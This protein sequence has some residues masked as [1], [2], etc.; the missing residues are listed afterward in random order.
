TRVYAKACLEVADR[1]EVHAMAHITGGGLAANLARV[2]PDS[3]EAT[4][5][6]AT[7]TLPA[8]FEVTR[9]VGGLTRADV[10]QA[11]NCGVGMVLVLPPSEV[12]TAVDVLGGYG[13]RAWVAGEVAEAAPGAAEAEPGAVG[14]GV[15]LVGEHAG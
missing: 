14:G 13:M 1:A 15:Q 4:L 3:V 6:R 8:V 10:E 11:L 5:D 9:Q 2:L 7:W 12:A